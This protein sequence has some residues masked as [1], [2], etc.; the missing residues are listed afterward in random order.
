MNTHGEQLPEIPMELV[1]ERAHALWRGRGCP[2][3]DADTDWL[4]A[5]RE[6]ADESRAACT[7]PPRFES[8]AG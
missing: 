6:L 7:H 1:A 4:A 5:E 3:G 8:S 2:M